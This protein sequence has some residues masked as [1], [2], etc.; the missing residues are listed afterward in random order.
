MGKRKTTEEFIEQ[1]KAVHGDKYDYSRV[2]YTNT[3]GKVCI[4][5]QEHGEFWQS[6]SSHLSGRNC[7]ICGELARR[8]NKTISSEE[9]LRRFRVLYGEK[10]DY[11]FSECVG[12]RGYIKI[13]CKSHNIWFKQKVLHHLNGHQ[14]KLC[15]K[16]GS[17]YTT[18]DFILR[19]KEVH[20]NLYNYDKVNY[21][22]KE[23][24]V[25]IICKKHGSFWQ[26]PHNHINGCG[27][28]LCK[29]TKTQLKVFNLLKKSFPDEEWFWEYQPTWLGLQR[30][31]I[32]NKRC[33][34]AIEYNGR[35]HYEPVDTFGGENAFRF[36]VQRDI[37]KLEKCKNNNCTLY[38]IKYDEFNTKKIIDDIS[39]LLNKN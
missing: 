14:C 9:L 7:P 30:F 25:E 34:L 8:K 27:C 17:S 29:A 13:F 24:P 23:T 6:P 39:E 20:G 26:K 33:N 18:E 36:T 2:E 35:Q 1:A 31:D 10:Y 5:C 16:G 22:N 38:I 3:K 4:I 19:A 12:A 28:Q 32:Y 11:D 21:I 37:L 15:S